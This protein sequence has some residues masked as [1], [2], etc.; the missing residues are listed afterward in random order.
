MGMSEGTERIA[1]EYG[2]NEINSE[3][4]GWRI[5]QLKHWEYE[6]EKEYDD[7]EISYFVCSVKAVLNM[8]LGT[9]LCSATLGM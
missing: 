9:G 1:K 4:M 5:V 3:S 7:K 6:G 2:F 8:D